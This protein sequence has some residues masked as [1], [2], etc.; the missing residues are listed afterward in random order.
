MRKI[1]LMVVLLL[2]ALPTA[3]QAEDQ[4]AIYTVTFAA[5]WSQATHPHPAGASNFPNNA[6]WSPLVGGV[7]NADVSFWAVGEAASPGIEQMAERGATGTLINEIK[8]AGTDYFVILLGPGIGTSPGQA[9]IARFSVSR[10]HPLVTLVTM[11]APSPDW[12]TGV[13]GLSLVDAN[14]QWHDRIE[15][16]VYPYDAGTD[17]GVDYTSA[18][19]EPTPHHLIADY[20]SVAPFA[21][22]PVGKFIFTRI[23]QNYFPLVMVAQSGVK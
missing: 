21:N 5:T 16:D 23:Q 12:F 4:T 17:D 11:V 2:L 13:A 22:Q 20:T 1:T 7:H 8:A 9:T 6:H 3:A 10:E 19:I 18:D 14:G 15:V